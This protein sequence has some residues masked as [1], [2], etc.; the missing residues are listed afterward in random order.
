MKK[1]TVT[2][3]DTVILCLMGVFLIAAMGNVEIKLKAPVSKLMPA[4]SIFTTFSS[5]TTLYFL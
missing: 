2:K 5:E 4:S 3:K 1:L